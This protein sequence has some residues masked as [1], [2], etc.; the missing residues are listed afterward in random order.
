MTNK[1][2]FSNKSEIVSFVCLCR[3]ENLLSAPKLT[4]AM[5]ACSFNDFSLSLC[6]PIPSS[7][8]LYKFKRHELNF[9]PLFAST[10]CFSVT[11]SS[12]HARACLVVFEYV[13]E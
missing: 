5:G 4:E 8:L 2:P 12:V 7:P 1:L 3:K 11:N 9:A 6:H 10:S 13:Y